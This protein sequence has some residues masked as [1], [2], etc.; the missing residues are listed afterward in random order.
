MLF[1]AGVSQLLIFIYK[2]KNG[3]EEMYQTANT[4]KSIRYNKLVLNTNENYI[5]RK[6]NIFEI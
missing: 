2:L 5:I 1:K 6:A 3:G 4:Q